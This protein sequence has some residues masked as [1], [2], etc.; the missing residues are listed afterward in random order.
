MTQKKSP[1]LDADI[2][3]LAVC[4]IY[5]RSLNLSNIFVLNPFISNEIMIAIL[6]H[7]ILHIN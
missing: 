6:N 1:Y 2:T 5:S 3:I 7:S 4:L